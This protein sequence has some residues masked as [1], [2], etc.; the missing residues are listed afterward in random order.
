[1]KRVRLINLLLAPIIIVALFSGCSPAV[2]T[3]GN[4][5]GNIANG[6][7]AAAQG[8]WI[9]YSSK[10]E[11]K[12]YKEKKDGSEKTAVTNDS[13]SDINVAGDWIYYKNNSDGGR[14][15]KIKADGTGRTRLNDVNSNSINV[16]GEWIYYYAGGIIEGFKLYKMKLDGTGITKLSEDRIPLNS[17]FC[18]E[19][20]WIY[21]T[22]GSTL[23]GSIY[24][25]KTDGTGKTKINEDKSAYI[26]IAGDWIYFSNNA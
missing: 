20:E 22:T 12:M 23:S 13:A 5:S 16:S 3:Q 2:N 8:S 26:N 25:M 19:G 6:G 17:S 4:T 11:G 24:K 1:M 14:I 10:S 15:Y 7:Y 18:V 9:Y 21:Y